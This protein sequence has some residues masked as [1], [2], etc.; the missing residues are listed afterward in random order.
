MKHHIQLL[1]AVN[2]LYL[3]FL[4]TA[5]KAGKLTPY[6]VEQSSTYDTD[7]AKY[8]VDGIITSVSHTQRDNPSWFR[9]HFQKSIYPS[10]IIVINGKSDRFLVWLDNAEV[11]ILTSDNSK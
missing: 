11:F 9:F 8:A 1:S 4:C 7:Y 2:L 5:T 10:K 3:S 6:F